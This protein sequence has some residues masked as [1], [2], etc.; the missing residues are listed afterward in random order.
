M[1]SE[2]LE[3]PSAD[4]W[5]P[6]PR[7][8]VVTASQFQDVVW[9]GERFVAVAMS[10]AGWVVLTSADGIRWLAPTPET[11]RGITQVALAPDG[12]IVGSGSGEEGGGTWASAD[13]ITWTPLSEQA[14][15]GS[16]AIATR[17]WVAV[18]TDW[19]GEPCASDCTPVRG[20]VWTSADGSQWT[21]AP[22][23]ESL[24]GADLRVVADYDGGWVA[25]GSIGGDAATWASRDGVSWDRSN[26]SALTVSANGLRTLVMD[27]VVDASVLV[28][29]GTEA[30]Q[31][32]SRARAWWSEDGEQWQAADV[33]GAID[34][35]MFSVAW[36]GAEL[37][38]AGPSS[39]CAGGLWASGDARAWTCVANGDRIGLFAPYAVSASPSVEIAVGITNEGF[40]EDSTGAMPGAVWWRG[41]P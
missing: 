31:D 33:D 38:A 18:G 12:T 30:G 10:D 4:G 14:I 36:T 3:S 25:A 22:D 21:P 29:V 24:R 7:Q 37:L 15:P 8:G 34:S 27:V 19:G 5:R 20:L 11:P 17:G 16:V 23:D 9:T 32:A 41:H 40:N 39:G 26:S 1:A 6:V 2:L 13:G 28:A 35:Q